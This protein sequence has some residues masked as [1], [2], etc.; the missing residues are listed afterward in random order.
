MITLGPCPAMQWS[1]LGPRACR[2][3]QEVVIIELPVQWSGLLGY[4]G[5]VTRKSCEKPA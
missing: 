5:L 2:V 4:Q 1:S 3:A